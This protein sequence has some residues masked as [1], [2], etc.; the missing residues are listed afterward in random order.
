VFTAGFYTPGFSFFS[1][2]PEMDPTRSFRGS[3][4]VPY[5]SLYTGNQSD[6]FGLGFEFLRPKIEKSQTSFVLDPV[7][8]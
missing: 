3:R 7:V 2:E 1:G 6:A 8:N 5:F 4:A